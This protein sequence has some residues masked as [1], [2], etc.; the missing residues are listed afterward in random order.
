MFAGRPPYELVAG[1]ELDDDDEVVVEVA[2]LASAAPPTAAAPTA[3]PVA[4]MDLSFLM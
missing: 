3:A 2:A 4:S 1:A